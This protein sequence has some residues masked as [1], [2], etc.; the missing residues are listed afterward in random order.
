MFGIMTYMDSEGHL[1]IVAT[2]IGNLQDIT[3]RAIEIL[4][5]SD[6][7]VCE[8]SRVTGKLLHHLGFKKPM[9]ALNEFNE[10]TV[11]YE[12]IHLL[13]QGKKISLVSDSGTPL[14][15]DPGFILV[16]L[17]RKKG[18]P[19]TPIPGA[20]AVIAALSASGLPS[21]SFLF[22]GFLPKNNSK[23]KKT[24][25]T[26]SEMTQLDLSPTIIFYESP[27][28]IV[29]TLILLHEICGDREILIAR[30]LTK[31]YESFHSNTISKL[32]TEFST[33][34]P[35]GEITVLLSLK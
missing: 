18:I 7:I 3:L 1:Y 23:K 30:E 28:R 19:V 33:K 9:M 24:L 14:I 4:K 31:I 34:Q 26:I 29:D 21:D 5:D 32:I 2:P 8:D 11:A 17:A 35:K 6:V 12:I 25:T 10:E 22:L 27:H 20:S 15:S 16:R 13:Q